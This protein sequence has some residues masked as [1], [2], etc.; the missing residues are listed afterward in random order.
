[1]ISAAGIK[2]QE[3]TIIVSMMLIELALLRL[4]RFKR[5]ALLDTRGL[6]LLVALHPRVWW[7][8]SG[9]LASVRRNPSV[10]GSE[11]AGDWGWHR[12]R[13][14]DHRI[15]VSHDD[16]SRDVLASSPDTCPGQISWDYDRRWRRACDQR[17]SGDSSA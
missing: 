2:D 3:L 13:E 12:E 6:E 9:Q 7:A 16:F 8:R 14:Q 17:L 1:M 5:L 10:S 11:K 15:A 4:S